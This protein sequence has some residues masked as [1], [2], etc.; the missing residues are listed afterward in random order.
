MN[1][2]NT[3]FC[4]GIL[5]LYHLKNTPVTRNAVHIIFQLP[6]SSFCARAIKNINTLLKVRRVTPIYN[7]SPY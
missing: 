2:F 4:R 3:T 7:T 5:Q 6:Q 1:N